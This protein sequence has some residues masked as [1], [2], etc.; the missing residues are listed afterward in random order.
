MSRRA[1]TLVEVLI[2]MMILTIMASVVITSANWGGPQ[3][4]ESA[5]RVLAADLRLARSLAVQYNTEWSV[6]FRSSNDSY[7]IVH[8]GTGN[9]PPL[10]DPLAP[11]GQGYRV[12]LNRLGT[13][14]GSDNGIRL[15]GLALEDSGSNVTDVTFSPLGGTGP[16]R[17][18]NTVILLAGRS[19]TNVQT[20]RLTVSWVTGQVWIE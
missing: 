13:S 3:T 18:E 17:N 10:E 11:A 6:L 2:T 7:E 15:A 14:T 5:A 8:T 20:V 9:P 1:F 4:L 19:G 12:E 16:L